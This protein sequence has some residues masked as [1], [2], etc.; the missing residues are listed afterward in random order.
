MLTPPLGPLMWTKGTTREV[1][2]EMSIFKCS[3]QNGNYL[4]ELMTVGDVGSC[5][6]WNIDSRRR[7]ENGKILSLWG[8]ELKKSV[9]RRSRALIKINEK[10]NEREV[11]GEKISMELNHHT[12]SKFAANYIGSGTDWTFQALSGRQNIVKAQ[13]GVTSCVK[14][15]WLVIQQKRC[16]MFPELCFPFCLA[17]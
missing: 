16:C 12:C 14:C 17:T 1:H 13:E 15:T 5:S 3:Y 11:W 8:E 4:K 10:Q 9:V 2:R 7:V 6:Q